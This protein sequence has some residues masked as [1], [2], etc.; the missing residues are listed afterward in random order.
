MEK[1]M[2]PC[3]NKWLFGVDCAGCGLQRSI[4]LLAHGKFSQAFLLYPAIYTLILLGISLA[5]HLMDKKRKYDKIVIVLAIFNGV[6]M[7]ISYIYKMMP[8]LTK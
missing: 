6:V 1:Y 8:L 2:L 5:L 7:T 3:L 4:I